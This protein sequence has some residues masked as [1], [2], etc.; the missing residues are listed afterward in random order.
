MKHENIKTA[1]RSTYSNRNPHMNMVHKAKD[2]LLNEKYAGKDVRA[3]IVPPIPDLF[4]VDFE[5]R[6]VIG[7]EVTGRGDQRRIKEKNYQGSD[8]DDFLMVQFMGIG[9]ES[10]KIYRLKRRHIGNCQ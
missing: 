5:N 9:G 4:L 2:L 3:I 7:I 10:H 8:F 1:K 6:K